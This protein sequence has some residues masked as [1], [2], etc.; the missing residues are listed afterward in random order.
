MTTS[1]ASNAKPYE[2]LKAWSACHDFVL[3]VYRATSKWP[4][5]EMYGLTAQVRR[6]A[7]SAAV[8]LAEGSMRR[9]SREFRRFLD[10]SLG[11][12]AEVSYTLK[13]ATDL[14]Y[15]PKEQQTEIEILRDHANRLTWGLYRAMAK[16]AMAKEGGSQ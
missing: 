11:S 8:N 4:R 1:N 16:A 14:G 5:E 2:R 7:L 13:L 12:L 6:S 15:L 3:G 10:V 9:G